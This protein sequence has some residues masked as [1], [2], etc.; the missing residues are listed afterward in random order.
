MRWDAAQYSSCGSRHEKC[1]TKALGDV[2]ILLPSGLTSFLALQ[3]SFSGA[4]VTGLT[5]FVF[6]L[7]HLDGRN[8]AELQLE[9]C[10]LESEQ[11]LRGQRGSSPS[12]C[13]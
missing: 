9:R 11:L 10:K 13:S 1:W 7:L 5:Y 8:V 4:A 12:R 3:S 6:D 2:P